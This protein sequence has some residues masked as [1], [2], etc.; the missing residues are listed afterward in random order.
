M[1]YVWRR[2][3]RDGDVHEDISEERMRDALAN[4]T[5]PGTLSYAPTDNPNRI[6]VLGPLGGDIVDHAYRIEI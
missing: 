3:R 4:G 2:F 1:A 5:R 6:A